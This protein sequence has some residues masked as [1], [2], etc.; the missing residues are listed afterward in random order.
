LSVA[1]DI[2]DNFGVNGVGGLTRGFSPG[3][4]KWGS[5]VFTEDINILFGDRGDFSAIV[6]DLSHASRVRWERAMERVRRLVDIQTR[7]GGR[8]LVSAMSFRPTNSPDAYATLFHSHYARLGI[9]AP[10]MVSSFLPGSGTIL[11]HD[12]HPNRRGHTLLRDQ[13]IHALH[14]L[15]WIGVPDTALPRLR[16]KTPVRLNPERD[17][18]PYERH[19]RALVSRLTDAVDFTAVRPRQARGFLGGMFPEPSSS[20]GMETWAAQRAAFLLRPPPGGLN[21]VEVEIEI[22]PRAE[23]FP[24][25]LRLLLDGTEAATAVF[26]RPQESGVYR[27]SGRPAGGVTQRDVVEV[28]LETDSYFS[29]VDDHG[30]KSYRLRRAR[31]F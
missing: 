11:R 25:S 5:A 3:A 6:W 12:S 9:P 2:S 24:F 10:F 7:R 13:Y 21:G 20:G 30:M 27:V 1:N 22:P 19:R 29:T 14:Q 26:E 28:A 23:L 18:A 16:R 8:V 31:A 17:S 4:R 15:G